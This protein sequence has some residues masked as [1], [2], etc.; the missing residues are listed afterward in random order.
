LPSPASGQDCTFCLRYES[1]GSSTLNNVDVGIALCDSQGRWLTRLSTTVTESLFD[2]VAQKGV[3][4]CRVSRLP[5]TV[6]DYGMG[7]RVAANGEVVD[8]II[9]AGKFTVSEGD[10]FGTGRIETH[11]PV[12]ILHDWKNE[13]DVGTGHFPSGDATHM[14]AR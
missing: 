12:L 7:F 14:A 8:Y 5:L 13:S 2:G 6:G 4:K 11:S 10:F 3:F 1:H 9:N